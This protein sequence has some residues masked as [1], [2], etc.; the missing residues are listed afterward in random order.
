MAR[1]DVYR[2]RN[3]EIVLDCQSDHLAHL[4]SRFVVPL[5]P[6]R[7]ISLGVR[8][9]NP[10]FV[11][12]DMPLIMATQFARAIERRSIRTTIASLSEEQDAI[13]DALDVLL[14]GV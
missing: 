1:F 7:D 11:V 3:D 12:D 2:L 9:L 10:R 13:I 4:S 14:T 8:R 6:G 5:R